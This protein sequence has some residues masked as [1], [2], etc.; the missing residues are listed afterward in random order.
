MTVTGPGPESPSEARQFVL[1]TDGGYAYAVSGADLH[2][3]QG[4]GPAF[5]LGEYRPGAGRGD[6]SSA[7]PSR[8]L[9]AR[10]QIVDFTGRGRELTE[11]A[12]WRDGRETR[13]AARWLYAPGGQGK[14]RLAMRFAEQSAAAGWKSVVAR[15][16]TGE[17]LPSPGSVDLRLGKDVGVL[18]LVDYAD[19]WPASHL[20]WLLSNALLHHGLPTRILLLARSFTPWPEVRAELAGLSAATDE[21]ELAPIHA[22]AVGTGERDAMFAVARDCFARC[23]GIADPSAVRTPGPLTDPA[24]GLTLSLH[25]AALVAVD[26]HA[27]G[28]EP[29]E[30]VADMSGYLLDRERAHWSKLYENRLAGLDYDTPACTMA[31]AVFTATLTGPMTY[32]RGVSLLEGLRLEVPADRVVTDHAACYPPAAPA[33]VA[34][35]L[36]PDRLA[37]DFIALSLPGHGRSA[38]RPALWALDTVKYLA[39]HAAEGAAPEI[40]RRMITVLAAAAAPDRWPHVAG[41]LEAIVRAD[42]ALAVAAGSAGLAALAALDLDPEVLEAVAAC[43]PD[44]ARADLDVGAALLVERLAGRRLARVRDPGRRAGLYQDYAA[45]LRNAGRFAEASSAG[46]RAV[47]LYVLATDS[48]GSVP[49][50]FGSVLSSLGGALFALG[51]EQA[52]IAASRYAVAQ[53]LAAARSRPGDATA[54]PLST[55]LHLLAAQLAESGESEEA[56]V[57]GGQAVTIRRELAAEDPRTFEPELAE[58]LSSLSSQ[59][60]RLDRW[61]QAYPASEEAVAILR[62]LSVAEPPRYAPRLAAALH[63]S[64]LAAL[65]LGRTDQALEATGH[66]VEIRRGLAEANPA[67]YRRALAGSLTNLGACRAVLGRG[68]EALAAAEESVLLWQESAAADPSPAV[69]ESLALALAN[70]RSLREGGSA[71]PADAERTQSPM[72]PALAAAARARGIPVIELSPAE[73][74]G[75]GGALAELRVQ[76]LIAAGRLEEAATVYEQEVASCRQNPAAFAAGGIALSARLTRALDLRLAKALSNLAVTEAD[77]RRF[78]Q[79]LEHSAEAVRIHRRLVTGEPESVN[80]LAQALTVFAGIRADTQTDL[81]EA[82]DAIAEL[83]G[84]VL[85]QPRAEYTNM[86]TFY[87]QFGA[88][89]LDLLRR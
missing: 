26:A 68:A 10:A 37:E 25:M 49:R 50:Q 52:G 38:H 61:A 80:L 64:G 77:L 23:Y 72:I 29:P 54:Y 12:A 42:P 17:I 66:A 46:W 28:A 35:P 45:R 48:T 3:H 18:L 53:C 39:A 89:L 63:H 71:R 14:T 84:I 88:Q 76:G 13:L 85:P 11:L 65:R 2:V 87:R 62:G 7:R 31:R 43:L 81:L 86:L 75:V 24:F 4:R 8:L 69:D 19:R 73:M 60:G 79:A 82:V 1:A 56:T 5:Q 22:E 16:G 67:V 15:H 83:I 6:P 21:S 44:H 33:T 30:R 70:L 59:L 47:G 34:E 41:H 20:T 32:G 27:R 36:L 55:A 9:D 74:A 40:A 58:S 51:H 57:L 78:P